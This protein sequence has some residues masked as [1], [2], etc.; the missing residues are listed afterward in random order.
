LIIFLETFRDL[1]V[2]A[3]DATSQS[4]PDARANLNKVEAAEEG[5]LLSESTKYTA[6]RAHRLT[7]TSTQP[8]FPLPATRAKLRFPKIIFLKIHKV[9]NIIT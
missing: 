7:L 8:S 9:N 2:T 6:S 4:S 1:F 3:I 5:L